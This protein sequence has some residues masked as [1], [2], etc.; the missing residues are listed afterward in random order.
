MRERARLAVRRI[1]EAA[2]FEVEDLESPLDL[3]AV[4]ND[5]CMIVL[6]SDDAGEIEEFDRTGYR[7][8]LGDQE[9]ASRKLLLTFS[10]HP[11]TSQCIRWGR[12]QLERYAG[13]AALAYILQKPLALE[14]GSATPMIVRKE[15]VPQELTGPEIPHLP[16]KVDEARA[17]SMTGAEGEALC[18]FIPY[19]YFHYHSQGQKSFGSQVVSFNAEKSGALNAINGQETELDIAKV[20]T[21]GI[22]IHSLVLQPVIPKN[23]AEEKIRTQVVDQQTQKVRVR[24]A[25]GDTIFYEERVFKPERKDITVDLQ[26]VY[27]PVWQFKGK[28]IAELNAFTGEVLREPMDTGA[29]IL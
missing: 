3:S 23:D 20:Q 21:T 1:L 10:D 29:E 22:P 2:S 28:K 15:T 14:L 27:I 25:K 26:M 7:C 9:V 19:W 16:M 12:D 6:C 8:R 5:T 24:Q 11:A 13:Q 18:R 17:R 4:R